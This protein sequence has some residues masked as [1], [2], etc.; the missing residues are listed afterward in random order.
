VPVPVFEITEHQGLIPGQGQ[1]QA[2]AL[3]PPRLQHG[4]GPGVD[5]DHPPRPPGL[6][7]LLP[8]LGTLTI[9]ADHAHG[10]LD[11]DRASLQVGVP[12]A[13][14]Q[15]LTAPHAGVGQRVP[16]HMQIAVLP[17]PAQERLQLA[18]KVDDLGAVVAERMPDLDGPHGRETIAAALI[19][20]AGLWPIANPASRVTAMFAEDPA[21]TRAHF[22]FEDRLQ[23]LLST[24]ITGFL[25]TAI[26]KPRRPPATVTPDPPKAPQGH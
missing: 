25:N 20:T 18:G 6:R 14:R 5:V 22:D 24:L 2:A 13:Q 4:H 8:D 19:I 11:A 17:R 23:Q 26:P 7:H 15:Q 3:T 9:V 16:R 1:S 21:L 10:S 12:P